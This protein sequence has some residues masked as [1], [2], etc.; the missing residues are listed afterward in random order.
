M[1][2]H[3]A[4]VG[5]LVVGM[6]A[7]GGVSIAEVASAAPEQ[8]VTQKLGWKLCN[9]SSSHPA[10][11]RME[12][13]LTKV[14]QNWNNPSA[15]VD[16]SIAV[17]RL[18]PEKGEPEGSIFGNPGGPGG[19]GIG[20]P[21]LLNERPELAKRFELVGFDPRG[22]GNSTNITCAGG[23]DFA[24]I[25]ARDRDQD[26][27]N[28][29][30]DASKLYGDFC[31][32]KSGEMLDFINTE[33]T[34]MDMDLLRSLLGRNRIHFVGYSAG[35][36]MGAY[37]ATYF[38]QHTGRFVLDSNTVFTGTWNDS[39]RLQPMA[40]E[41]RFRQD[42]AVWAA[43]YP[44][45]LGLGA[46]QSDVIRYYEKLRADV[47]KKSIV[48]YFEDAEVTFTQN[49]V[50]YVIVSAM[51]T[52]SR[53]PALGEDLRSLRALADAQASGGRA[54]AQ[55]AFDALPEAEQQTLVNAVEEAAVVQR[56]FARPLAQP[57]ARPL[58]RPFAADA[59]DATF[60][61]ITCNDTEWPR[62][63][64]YWDTLSAEQGPKYPILGWG[65]N[66]NPCA[67]WQ[68]PALDMPTPDGEGTFGS[69]MIQ[70][71][72]DAATAYEGAVQAHRDFA[73]SRLVVVENEGDHG[74]YVGVN[75]CVDQ[76]ADRYLTTGNLPQRDTTICRG[77]GIPAPSNAAR[78][79]MP[80]GGSPLDRAREYAA[81]VRG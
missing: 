6:L 74:I 4:L 62:G 48:I 79:G 78:S 32:E 3:A 49:I 73:G 11:K 43:T 14:P 24:S 19:E 50:D 55:R 29:I 2:R 8:Y 45:D 64:R 80:S 31:H 42:F 16:L 22:T 38:P 67:Y 37:Y 60:N 53:F 58:G 47:K 51:Y 75:S 65:M 9:P 20:M 61:A 18:R 68:R 10:V 1:R 44:T 12:C 69:L 66:Q 36:W 28:L 81:M 30:A 5:A 71:K 57:F 21:V 77:S 70:S 52:K 46:S 23:P 15:G 26:N 35:T 27:R 54:A 17:S 7:S 39:F 41:R 33:Q 13:A 76:I 56:P 59:S 25:D 40:F 63:E 72:H 34:I